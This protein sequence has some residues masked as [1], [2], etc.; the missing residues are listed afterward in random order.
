MLR[1]YE[2][3][4]DSCRARLYSIIFNRF[5]NLSAI[6]LNLIV[7]SS[8][9]LVGYDARLTRERSRVRAS[10]RILPKFFSQKNWTTRNFFFSHHINFEKKKLSSRTAAHCIIG[11]GSTIRVV[12][13]RLWSWYKPVLG[14]T[15]SFMERCGIVAYK[16]FQNWLRVSSLLFAFYK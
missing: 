4:F 16:F 15:T 6:Q 12:L 3:G 2:K 14:L 9:G 13:K 10:V 1:R 8:H 7:G 11:R 5:S